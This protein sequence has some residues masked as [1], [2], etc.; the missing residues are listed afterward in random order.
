MKEKKLYGNDLTIANKKFRASKEYK[1][2]K[3]SILERDKYVCQKCGV[4]KYNVLKPPQI[5]VHHI[6]SF[7][8]FPDLRLEP[9]NCITL[10]K[11]CHKKTDTYGYIGCYDKID[12]YKASD[13][14]FW[15]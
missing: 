7:N 15:Y 14:N 3:V 11:D 8:D 5:H 9:D 4:G 13:L 6:K 2:F 1:D 10:C 12:N